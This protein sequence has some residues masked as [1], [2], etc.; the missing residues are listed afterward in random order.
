M[1]RR[2]LRDLL[3]QTAPDTEL[4]FEPGR[5]GVSAR[6]IEE[7]LAARGSL[8]RHLAGADVAVAAGD[9]RELVESLLL[10]DG[11][12]RRLTLVSPTAPADRVASILERAGTD[13]VVSAAP[14]F[15][16][17]GGEVL[18]PDP[19]AAPATAPPL[20]DTTWVLPTSG[21]TGAPK[22]VA[23]SL[24]DLTRTVRREPDPTR[25]HRWGSLYDLTG[26]A[27]LQVFLQSW[28]SESCLILGRGRGV[29]ERLGELVEGGC[30]ALSATPTMWRKLLMSP[31]VERLS[32]RQITLGGEIVDQAVLDALGRAFPDARITH[33]YASTEAGVGFAVGDAKA[34]FPAAWLEEPPRGVRLAVEDGALLVRAE[35]ARQEYVEPDARLRRGDGFLDTGDRVVRRGDR[36]FFVGRAGGIINVGGNKVHPEQVEAFLLGCDGVRLARVSGRDSPITGSLVQAEVV[37]DPAL[38]TDPD[39]SRRSILNRCREGLE[40]WAVPAILNLVPSLDLTDSGKLKREAR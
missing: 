36:L 3:G 5:G 6:E 2:R 12:C 34:G 24:A 22:L 17:A 16:W 19:A 21:T 8:A 37:V 40:P 35:G 7:R 31:G 23:H 27:G 20:V 14:D 26:F 18:R 25:R 9:V 13:V 28:W 32:L 11:A 30:T 33:I 15:R 38:A 1:T 10:L 39:R 4:W 29:V